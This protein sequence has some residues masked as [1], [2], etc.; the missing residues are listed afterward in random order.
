MNKTCILCGAELAGSNRSWEHVVPESLGGKLR[1]DQVLCRSCNSRTGHDWDAALVRQL[2][3]F[4]LFVFPE[5]HPMGQR[6]R[7]LRDDQ[8]N[9][10]ILKSGLRGGSEHPQSSVRKLNDTS[11]LIISAPSKKRAVQE[12]ERLVSQGKLPAERKVEAIESLTREEVLTRIEFEESGSIGGD[13]TWRSMLKS[14]V[15]GGIMSGLTPSDM[16]PAVEFL[17][18]FDCAVQN[19]PIRTSPVYRTDTS[20]LPI[21]RH[22]VHVETDTDEQAVW[23]YLELFGTI[24]SLA[25]LGTQY[26]GPPTSW[27]YCVDPVTGTNLTDDVTVDLTA[28]KGLME[29]ARRA[30]KR[31]TEIWSENAPDL[32]PLMDECLRMHKV[33]GDIA[34]TE[35]SYGSIQPEEGAK[36]HEITLLT[37]EQSA[38][39]DSS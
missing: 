2:L 12:I 17:R 1:T 20:E 7:R 36:I 26:T 24:S 21:R 32:Q 13:D 27:S 18:G 38:S 39:D 14:M 8:G 16:L 37:N 9:S 4:S 23:G 3:P 35:T 22:C 31:V 5:R 19:L 30:P 15:T 28:P 11:E 10:L 6:S 29:D 33:V 34:I 25:Q